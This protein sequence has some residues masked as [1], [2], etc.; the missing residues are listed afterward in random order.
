VAGP[1]FPPHFGFLA[2][3]FPPD[4]HDRSI[5]LILDT[6]SNRPRPENSAQGGTALSCRFSLRPECSKSAS[7]SHE[8]RGS[9]AHILKPRASQCHRLLHPKFPNLW[10]RLGSGLRV[11]DRFKLNNPASLPEPCPVLCCAAFA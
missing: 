3:A 1:I 10:Q 4:Q 11:L 7:A 5:N 9:S 2:S 8:T 6:K